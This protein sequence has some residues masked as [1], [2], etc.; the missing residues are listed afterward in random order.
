MSTVTTEPGVATARRP[1]PG[2]GKGSRGGPSFW[3][4]T[5]ALAFFGLFALVPL[6]GVV[7]LSLMN[8]DG[9]GTPTWA[10]LDNW[11]RTFQDPVTRNAFVLTLQLT[12]LS[13]L[14]QA[15]ISLLLG[16]FMAGRQRYRALLS[17]LYFLPLLFS[18]AA[19][20]IAY[21]SLL[22]PNFG[23]G[24]ALGADW[25]SRDWLG[26]PD[27][28][29]FVVVWVIAWSFIPFHSLLY[30][31]GVRQI[32]LSMYE[33]ARLDGAST[34]RQFLSITLPQLKY[35][36]ITSSTL[37]IVGSLTYFDLIF[38]LTNGGPGNATR[39]LPLDMYLKGFRSYDMGGASVVAVILVFLGLTISLLLN[40]LSGAHRMESQMEGV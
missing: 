33:A 30:Q 1:A 18:A 7:V 35:T 27:L 20:A 19:V 4:A 3:F 17:V 32:P 12:A 31:S 34:V 11:I 22:D 38:V 26:D 13:W 16:V 9:L 40:R 14:I 28:A 23:I 8:W 10:G 24:S 25:L 36:I 37:M 5:P 39:V 15:P 6:V 29:F 2:R 21:K